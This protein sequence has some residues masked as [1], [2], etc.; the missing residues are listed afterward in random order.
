[1]H[2]ICLYALYDVRV[3]YVGVCVRSCM[4]VLLAC[5]CVCARVVQYKLSIVYMVEVEVGELDIQ[6][7]SIVL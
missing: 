4:S 3:E 5:V 7:E 2:F 1:M 6:E